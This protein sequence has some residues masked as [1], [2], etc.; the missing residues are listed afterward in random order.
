MDFQSY[1]TQAGKK[2]ID[3]LLVP[4]SD[5]KEIDPI[6]TEM[7]SFRAV[8]NGFNFVRQAQKG[9]SLSA[10]YLGQTISSIDYFNT[11]DKVMISHVPM[12]G[13]DTIYSIMGDY[14][15]W[16]S[17]SAFVVLAIYTFLKRK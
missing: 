16:I 13:T 17:V 3:I 7:A 10:N 11:D 14:F 15:A 5:W 6:H 8:E 4:G 12:K 9:Y 1:L 2:N